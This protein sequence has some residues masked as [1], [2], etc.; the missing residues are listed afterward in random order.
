[1]NFQN[2]NKTEAVD[3]T[4]DS[5]RKTILSKDSQTTQAAK[6]SKKVFTPKPKKVSLKSPF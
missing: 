2:R 3:A 5:L 4:F 6:E 1:M